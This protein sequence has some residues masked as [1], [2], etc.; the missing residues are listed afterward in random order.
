MSKP[1]VHC[2]FETRSAVDLKVVGQYRY[3]EDPTTEIICLRYRVGDGPVLG[4]RPGEPLPAVF[5]GDFEM[6]A[7]K[8]DFERCIWNAKMPALMVMAK[9]QSCTMARAQA[10][11]LPGAL[12]PLGKA[13][14]LDDTKDMDGHSLMLKLCKPKGYEPDGR[15]IWH[16]DPAEH[17]RLYDYC[18]QDVVTECG[19]D[20]RV[21]RLPDFERRVWELDQKINDRG[22]QVDAEMVYAAAGAVKEAVRRANERMTALTDGYVSTVSQVGKIVQWINLQDVPCKSIG[23]KEHE[24]LITSADLASRPEVREVIELRGASAKAFKFE[25]ILNNMNSDGRVRGSLRYNGTISRRWAGAGVQPHNM[26]RVETE[27]DA[28][29]VAMAVEVLKSGQSPK[30]IV[31]ELELM[32]ESPLG[33]LSLCTRSSIISRKGHRLIGGD[34]SNIEGRENAWIAGSEAK[35][36]AFRAYDQGKGPDLYKVTAGSIIGVEPGMVSKAQRQE[37]GK[38]PELAC[39]FQGALGAFKKMGAK[40][41]V[42]LADGRI[43]E[44]VHGW[45]ETPH[46]VPIV[47]SWALYQ[48]AAIDAVLSKGSIVSLLG[49]KVKY[50]SDGRFLY[51]KL[52]SRGVIYYPSPS[53]AWKSKTLVSEDGD[54]YELNRLTVSYW[55]AE[56]GRWVRQDLYGGA[57]CAHIVSGTA[58]DVLCGAMLRAEAAGYPLVL[59]VHDE[60]LAEVPDDRGALEEYQSILLAKEYWMGDCPMAAKVWEG[61]VYVK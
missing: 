24:E 19:V 8:A 28:E 5:Q 17:A 4:W 44:I 49:G 57:Q 12:F 35:L 16:E 54:E 58:R 61:P 13:L 21:P 18:G 56:G 30:A 23:K 41:G 43:K 60:L 50:V 22:F 10:V 3:A 7:H 42:R 52:P 39:G 33:I 20:K 40:Y 2:D 38:V 26:K 34:F 25:A 11:G 47:D 31:D 46:N 36:D 51:C 53:V 15:P 37:Q 32:F 45:R 14:K 1:V 59:T 55:A 27:E 6:V 48:Q 9:D 29:S